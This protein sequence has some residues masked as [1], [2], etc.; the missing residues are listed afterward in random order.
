ML[1]HSSRAGYTHTQTLKYVYV[2]VCECA[3]HSQGHSF[4]FTFLALI[5]APTPTLKKKTTLS[6]R[7]VLH[8][9]LP[10]LPLYTSFSSLP[11]C[12]INSFQLWHESKLKKKTDGYTNHY[13]IEERKK[14]PE[15]KERDHKLK[16]GNPVSVCASQSFGLLSLFLSP[17][18]SLSL[19]LLLLWH[20]FPSQF[21]SAVV[22]RSVH[23]KHEKYFCWPQKL[24]LLCNFLKKVR[25]IELERE[26]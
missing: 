19:L 10:C 2:C 6:Q 23:N 12:P 21:T 13:T 25:Q 8:S 20:T 11:S 18:S 22:R 14:E 3:P 26:G 15:R 7:F 16:A 4:A 9:L 1:R 24:F 17:S 5:C